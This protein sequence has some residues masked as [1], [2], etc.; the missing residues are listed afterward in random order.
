MPKIGAA[1]ADLLVDTD[2]D[3]DMV[4]SVT[5]STDDGSFSLVGTAFRHGQFTQHEKIRWVAGGG[6][7]GSPIKPAA[8]SKQTTRSIL[9]KVM[10][11]VGEKPSSFVGTSSSG[12]LTPNFKLSLIASLKASLNINF[13]ANASLSL[14]GA[15]IGVS[16]QAG[17]SA[18]L[19]AAASAVGGGSLESSSI[20]NMLNS[21]FSSQLNPALKTSLSGLLTANICDSTI[22][23]W[24]SLETT[25][26]ARLNALASY[27]GGYWKIT[28]SGTTDLIIVDPW[29]A[30]DPTIDFEVINWNRNESWALIGCE[31]P[32]VYPGQTIVMNDGA[33][34]ESVEKISYITYSIESNSI[35]ATAYFEDE[36]LL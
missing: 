13:S 5:I 19:S 16:A 36:N 10:T 17:F 15:S 2:N 18:S 26:K 29:P 1:S 12:I 20:M 22:L 27:K 6:N 28:P 8:F 31:Q 23:R 11:T 33:G 21:P 35:R 14:R 7:L 4:G 3:S 32:F 30:V 34:N 24:S 9:T 25:G